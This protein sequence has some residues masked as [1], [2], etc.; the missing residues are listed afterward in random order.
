MF[1][2]ALAGGAHYLMSFLSQLKVI[3]III[4]LLNL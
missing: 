1:S 4:A 2:C 3:I